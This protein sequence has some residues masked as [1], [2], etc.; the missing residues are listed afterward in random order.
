M[1]R[2]PYNHLM[3]KETPVVVGLGEVLWDLLPGG[4]RFGGAP[5]N[6]A[7]HAKALGGE[8]Y[9]V[10]CV[11]GD[12]AGE[13]ILAELDR[14]GLSRDFVAVDPEHPTGTVSVALDAAGKPNYVIHE[15]VA[16]DFI[17]PRPELEGLARRTDAVCF[18]S[19]AQR[20][21]ISRT[22]IRDFIAACPDECLRVF[23]VN[24]RQ[25]YYNADTVAVGLELADV[26]KLSD[27]EFPIIARLLGVEGNG[28]ENS[29]RPLPP[30]QFAIDRLDEGGG[31][32]A[33]LDALGQF[34][35][36]RVSRQGGRHG[37]GGRQLYCR[38]R[39]GASSSS[40]AR[41][42]QRQGEQNCRVR[43]RSARG[44]AADAEGNRRAGVIRGG[45]PR[46]NSFFRD[47][48]NQQE[49]LL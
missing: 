23:D 44:H 11:G 49:E 21:P 33:A 13:E 17:A 1:P 5:A 34:A 4:K 47:Y 29:R 2:K 9:V 45:N 39:F 35:S 24:L 37:G 43:L 31:R 12:A 40:R 28:N 26:L 36:S 27:E 6:F 3:Q 32:L 7:Y 22:T 25:H 41:R 19:L 48:G 8:A 18:G 16:W 46:Y 20:S 15:G 10:S 14:L 42:D 30:L 38:G